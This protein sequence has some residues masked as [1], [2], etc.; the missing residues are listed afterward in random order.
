MIE[1][2]KRDIITQISAAETKARLDDKNENASRMKADGMA[3]ALITIYTG[4]SV[5]EIEK[6]V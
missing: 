1:N 6:H 4:L 3:V 2:G 5:G